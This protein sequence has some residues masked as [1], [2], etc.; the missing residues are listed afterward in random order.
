MLRD[1]VVLIHARSALPPFKFGY[2]NPFGW[3]AYFLNGTLFMKNFNPHPG[4][5][6]PDRGCNTACYC[7]DRF[8]ELES[9]GPLQT[10]EPG[11]TAI[12]IETWDLSTSLELSPLPP[13]LQTLLLQERFS[14]DPAAGLPSPN[15]PATPQDTE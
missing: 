15:K 10:L 5:L 12:H 3:Q 6:F 2:F 14:P 13:E 9:L 8:I 4:A 7:N 11:Q 1:D